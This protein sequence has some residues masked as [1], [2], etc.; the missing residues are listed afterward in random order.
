MR[1]LTALPKRQ[2]LNFIRRAASTKRGSRKN[3]RSPDRSTPLLTT[4][5]IKANREHFKAEWP[6]VGSVQTAIGRTTPTL[7][8]S[9][10]L[11]ERLLTN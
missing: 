3:D 10:A 7:S 2:R 4:Y 1:N 5:P 6:F 11:A 8:A 9:G